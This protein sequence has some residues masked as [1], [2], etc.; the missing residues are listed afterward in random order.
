MQSELPSTDDGGT[1]LVDEVR[2]LQII[3]E[4]GALIASQLDLEKVVRAVV[5]AGVELTGAEFGA[6]FYNAVGDDGEK[7]LLYALSGADP[8]HFSA[9]PHPRATPVFAPTFYGEGVIRS[10]DI[11]RDPRYGKMSP[12]HGMPKNHL[13]VRSYLAV[14]VISRSSEVLGGLFFGHAAPGRFRVSHERIMLGIA[15]QAAIAI[16]NARL[17]DA[18]RLELRRRQS[19][20]AT[21][22]QTERRL[23]AILDNATVAIFLMDDRQ[24]CIYMNAAAERL[25]GFA[26]DETVGRPLHD[27]I[28]HT[29]PDGSHFPLHECAIDRAFPEN[30]RQQGEEV[31][32]HKSGRFYP[33]A[34]TASPVRDEQGVTV[35]T[36][37]EVRDITEE[38]RSEETRSLLMREVDHRARNALAVVQSLVKLTTAGDLEA[39]KDKLLGRISALARAQGNLA[40]RKW[41]GASLHYIVCEELVTLCPRETFDVKGPDVLLRAEQAQPVSMVIHE[42]ATNAFKHGALSRPAGRVLVEWA[43][44]GPDLVIEWIETGGPPVRAPDRHGFGSKLIRQL[45][46]QVGASFEKDWLETGIRAR[47]RLPLERR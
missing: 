46:Q 22:G 7:L 31:F 9:F 6:F 38:R 5:D 39:Y 24:H 18:A 14:P 11:T 29:R 15:A 10:D 30:D 40:E 23:K 26:F 25:T 16:D 13:P 3:N 1:S 28:H 44:D 37:I 33:V 19:T 35:G 36:V 20:E 32:V 43:W 27:V 12:H 45:A 8:K 42:L 17:Y 21:L 47:M 4:T 2:A 41:E 34:F